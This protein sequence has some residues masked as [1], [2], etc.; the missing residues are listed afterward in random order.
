MEQ[1]LHLGPGI[2]EL[3]ERVLQVQPKVTALELGPGRMLM[4]MELPMQLPAVQVL[5]TVLGVGL[6]QD[7][8]QLR[9][10][11][12]YRKGHEIPPDHDPAQ[13][14]LSILQP[15]LHPFTNHL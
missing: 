13:R 3:P 5:V 7:L 11:I 9:E 8:E 2:T 15:L 14:L 12:R 1:E 10:R 4:D 6:G